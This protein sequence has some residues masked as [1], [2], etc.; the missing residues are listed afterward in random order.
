M[1]DILSRA[2]LMVYLY[3]L[4]LEYRQYNGPDKG[5]GSTEL[6]IKDVA[7][8]STWFWMERKTEGWE[9]FYE[10]YLSLVIV[11]RFSIFFISRSTETPTGVI[12]FLVEIDCFSVHQENQERNKEKLTRDPLF[13]GIPVF[14]GGPRSP[15]KGKIK[16]VNELKHEVRT[17]TN[18]LQERAWIDWLNPRGRTVLE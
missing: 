13:P 16:D 18:C 14:P 2:I 10:A 15:W 8:Y 1:S 9:F 7:S 12:G 6:S 11:H 5:T 4:M 3:V 17:L